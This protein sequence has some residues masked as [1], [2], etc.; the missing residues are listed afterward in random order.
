[1]I[2]GGSLGARRVNDAALGLYDRWRTR[3]DVAIHH[4]CGTRD[5]ADCAARLDAIRGPDDRLR[6][7]LV[8]YEERMDCL[9]AK[10]AIVVCRAGAVTVAELCAT[11]TP[12]VL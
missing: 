3:T 6:Y 2:F 8:A 7:E 4:I 5:H 10:A 1:G 11:G 9:Y 12:A